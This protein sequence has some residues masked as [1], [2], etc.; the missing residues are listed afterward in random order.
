M[1]LEL[2]AKNFE[3]YLSYDKVLYPHQREVFEKIIQDANAGNLNGALKAPT[4]IGKTI[5]I[6]SAVNA[7]T[8]SSNERALI[9]VPRKVL[10]EQTK[11]ELKDVIG[12]NKNKIGVYHSGKK[13]SERKDALDK[14]ILITTPSSLINLG[15]NGIITEEDFGYISLDEAHRM[16]GPR[17]RMVLDRFIENAITHAWSATPTFY[18]GTTISE[19]LFERD[20]FLFELNFKTAVE[21]GYLSPVKNIILQTNVDTSDLGAP[22]RELSAIDQRRFA[23]R[24]GRDDLAISLSKEFIDVENGVKFA[25]ETSIWYSTGIDHAKAIKQKLNELHG[26]GYSEVISG[27]TS[28]DRITKLLKAHKHGDLKALVNAEMLVEGWDNPKASIAY[29][30][31]DSISP[32]KI[33]QTGGRVTRIDK[34][35]PNK[36]A[37][38]VNL[39]DEGRPFSLTYSDVVGGYNIKPPK[40]KTNDLEGEKAGF[41]PDYDY[42][43]TFG[44]LIIVTSEDH[45]KFAKKRKAKQDELTFD[46]IPQGYL[47]KVP[48]LRKVGVAISNSQF[49]A[50]WKKTETTSKIGGKEIKSGFYFS[51]NGSRAFY[52]HEDETKIFKD[53]LGIKDFPSKPKDYLGMKTLSEKLGLSDS[54]KKFTDIYKNLQSTGEIDGVVIKSGFFN[55]VGKTIFCVHQNEISTIKQLLQISEYPLKPE[56]YLYKEA[57]SKQL[58]ISN[59]NSFYTKLWDEV[60]ESSMIDGVRTNSGFYKSGKG[61]AFYIHESEL[62]TFRQKLN[63]KE[64]HERPEG[65]L[66]KTNFLKKVGVTG[67]NQG[68]IILWDQVKSTGKIDGEDIKSGF[69]REG[70]NVANFYIHQDEVIKFKVKLGVKQKKPDGFLSKQAFAKRIGTTTKNSIYNRIWDQIEETGMIEGMRIKSGIY[71]GHTSNAFYIHQDEADKFK[72]KLEEIRTDRKRKPSNQIK[73]HSIAKAKG[74][75]HHQSKK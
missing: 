5:L 29:M 32:I 48:F 68:F 27:K 40:R 31:V 41:K 51:N 20:D 44:D 67:S 21:R 33:E 24:A 61:D 7:F 38:V 4:G 23:M 47:S 63:I 69:Y 64:Y 73:P 25:D 46:N 26:E 36:Q 66:Q 18:D 3:S 59:N 52:I 53:K 49:T 39:V 13:G 65:Y 14:Q 22:T 30:L 72:E 45:I 11:D 71:R 12:I 75:D 56:G 60:K 28:K 62:K 16:N 19:T 17:T 15:K 10:A 34:E 35:R 57:F 58:G 37:Y 2:F 8:S 6:G 70:L 9:L 42:S 1:K 50:L 74:G 54:N 55:F 43:K